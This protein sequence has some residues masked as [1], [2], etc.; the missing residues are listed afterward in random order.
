MLVSFPIKDEGTE[1][2]NGLGRS[3]IGRPLASNF[4]VVHRILPVMSIYNGKVM[5]RTIISQYCLFISDRSIGIKSH[6]E[7]KDKKSYYS[8]VKHIFERAI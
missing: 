2:C 1:N 3:D 7:S 4:T 5:A 6:K 8:K